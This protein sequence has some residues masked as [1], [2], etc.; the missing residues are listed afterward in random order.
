MLLAAY[1]LAFHFHRPVSELRMSMR[2]FMNW[3]AYLKIE[4]PEEPEDLRN[5]ALQAT[6][7]NMSGRSLNKGKFVTP[8]EL[9][10]KKPPEKAQSPE[11]Q[12][13]FLKAMSRKS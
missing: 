2:E 13:A 8:D 4:P 10:G 9:L 7:M 1:R 11:N 3:L 12:K 5:A 6:I